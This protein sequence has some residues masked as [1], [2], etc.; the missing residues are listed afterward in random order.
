MTLS[1]AVIQ[2]V[3]SDTGPLLNYTGGY[4]M[5]L[6]NITILYS[7]LDSLIAIQATSYVRMTGVTIT[8]TTF[9]PRSLSGDKK[10]PASLSFGA[11]YFWGIN[12]LQG[13]DVHFTNVTVKHT[14]LAVPY[15]LIA[16]D[17]VWVSDVVDLR[18]TS[19]STNGYLMSHRADRCDSA[20][21]G[22]E[23]SQPPNSSFEMSSS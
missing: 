14:G 6:S 8:S 20:I 23:S 3:K 19:S 11:L 5:L 4:K 21:I 10:I 1:N 12:K 18:V 9:V 17:C 13:T 2:N 22:N 15:S 16:C 7:Q